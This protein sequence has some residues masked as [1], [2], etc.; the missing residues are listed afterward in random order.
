METNPILDKTDTEYFSKK[1]ANL[2]HCEHLDN[3]NVASAL[4]SSITNKKQYFSR[5]EQQPF[6]TKQKHSEK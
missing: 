3:E 6:T 4:T 2:I 1:Q 5:Q